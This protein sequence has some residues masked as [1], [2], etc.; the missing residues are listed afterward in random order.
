MSRYLDLS[1]DPKSH[2][3]TLTRIGYTM[4]S[5]VSD[6]LDNS[7]AARARNIE[8]LSPP[9]LSDPL[10]S[11]IDDGT[12]M[13]PEELI[14]NMRIGCKDPT[15]EREKGDL[16][17]FGSGMKT[18]SFSQSRR[19][20]AIS[21]KMG[22]AA[23]AVIWDIDV[24]EKENRW[25]V[26][27]LEGDALK[28]LPL[29]KIND[30]TRQGTQLIWEK[31]TC[32]SSGDHAVDHD[33]EISAH[34]TDIRAHVA[35]HFHRFLSGQDRVA[36][37]INGRMIDPID[38]FLSICDGYQEG[39]SEKLRCKGGHIVIK[40]HVL[41]HIKKI[42]NNKLEELGGADGINKGQGLYIYREKRLII[43]GG[44]LGLAR[45]SQLGA[46][47]RVQVDIPS[48]L[49]HDWSTDVK[50]S[51]LQLPPKVKREIKKFLA[52]PIKR[53]QKTYTYRGKE[54][55]ANSFWKVIEDENNHTI[56]YNI[57]P[58]N[59][60][61][62]KILTKLESKDKAELIKYL[63]E[64]ALHVPINHIYQKM[65]EAPKDIKQETNT[66]SLFDSILNKVFER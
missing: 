30:D 3:K 26:E 21:K 43:A 19:L 25:C 50:K 8:I 17:R 16:G 45:N 66:R 6:I 55:T 33:E 31:L 51:S 9:G 48:T 46:L 2:I 38:P 54:D 18:A 34:I 57:D 65:S 29:L 15:L 36:I 4:S 23:T 20:T 5:A 52:D 60:E 64:L 28:N 37:Q 32:I 1:P 44:W 47:A 61:L 35:L 49:D 24:I 63:Q 62:I 40:T 42:P 41:P 14:A 27:I 11:I 22:H 59:T 53:S 10:I 12:G 58:N 7:I 39:R 13:D 56:S